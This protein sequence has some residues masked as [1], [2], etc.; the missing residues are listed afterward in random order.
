MT[1]WLNFWNSFAIRNTWAERAVQDCMSD[2]A[3]LLLFRKCEPVWC[4]FKM[5]S[6]T[7]FKHQKRLCSGILTAKPCASSYQNSAG[8]GEM[9]MLSLIFNTNS[10]IPASKALFARVTHLALVPVLLALH[11]FPWAGQAFHAV[12][13]PPPKGISPWPC[14]WSSELN[15]RKSIFICGV[16]VLFIEREKAGEELQ[17]LLQ[18]KPLHTLF[19]SRTLGSWKNP[20]ELCRSFHFHIRSCC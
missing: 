10:H 20:L 14:G 2:S 16:S 5:N 1:L 12:P 9:K 13:S 18:G 3:P 7:L 15:S 17:L 4:C 8:P 19:C 6:A 11:F